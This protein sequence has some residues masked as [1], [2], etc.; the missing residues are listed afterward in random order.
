MQTGRRTD[1]H[2]EANSRFSQF[3]ERAQKLLSQSLHGPQSPT[4][5]AYNHRNGT[6]IYCPDFTKP[7]KLLPCSQNLSSRFILI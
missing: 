3:C 6:K 5:E 7:E 4:R 2:V 1:R